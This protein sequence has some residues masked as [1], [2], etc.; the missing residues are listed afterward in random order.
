[1]INLGA[2]YGSAAIGVALA[3]LVALLF[4]YTF[5]LKS[6]RSGSKGTAAKICLLLGAVSA[7]FIF[8]GASI[9]FNE[10]IHSKSAGIRVSE[11]TLYR[12][13]LVSV[14][15]VL[16]LSIISWLIGFF[17]NSRNEIS[18]TSHIV[19]SAQRPTVDQ[20]LRRT[21]LI[22]Y[23]FIA[24]VIG[25]PLIAAYWH[26]ISNASKSNNSASLGSVNIYTSS[27]A[28]VP[29]TH[30]TTS[31]APELTPKSL[32]E[33]TPS[34]KGFQLDVTPESI[35]SYTPR[36]DECVVEVLS[37][38]ISVWR[39]DKRAGYAFYEVD[40]YGNRFLIYELANL[41][42][43]QIYTKIANRQD[44]IRRICGLS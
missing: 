36:P 20:Q 12:G 10:L 2:A 26:D 41:Q 5:Y 43:S 32:S 21:D 16:V 13:L 15:M 37:G 22:F 27:P 29:I 14:P 24:C 28:T 39:G 8:Q 34:P 11:D 3:M 31:A 1:M 19:S 25:I 38:S 6:Y 33:N 17:G 40:F 44:E 30:G 7:I 42:D 9:I 23:A 18:Q 4:F 35:G